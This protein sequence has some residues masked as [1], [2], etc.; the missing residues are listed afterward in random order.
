MISRLKGLGG[1]ID[2]DLD[3]TTIMQGLN[4]LFGL[5]TQSKL[6]K[7][8]KS[9][10]LKI[11]FVLTCYDRYSHLRSIAFHEW[12]V[13]GHSAKFENFVNIKMKR[14]N[15]YHIDAIPQANKML[16][17]YFLSL[18]RISTNDDWA[19]ENKSAFNKFIQDTVKSYA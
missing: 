4:K 9:K 2:W 11:D 7:G 1:I 15:S 12:I 6:L 16:E 13:Q 17:N 10:M 19:I 18:L 14:L 3:Y 8:L 5:K